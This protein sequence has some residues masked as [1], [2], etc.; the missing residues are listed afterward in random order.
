MTAEARRQYINLKRERYLASS[1]REERGHM[2]RELVRDGIYK[3]VK[4]ANRAM[5]EVQDTRY[6]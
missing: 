2:L 6:R 3:S 4:S 5:L 1:S